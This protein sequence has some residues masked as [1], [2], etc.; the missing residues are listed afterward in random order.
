LH[1]ADIARELGIRTVI[2]PNYPG[3]FCAYGML[4][5]DLKYDVVQ[6]MAMGLEQLDLA[7]ADKQFAVLEDRGRTSL[8]DI[9]VV[10][11]A[12]FVARFADMRYRGQE[13]TLK[14]RLPEKMSFTSQSDMRNAFEAEYT[15]RY[16]HSSKNV[17]I[18]LVNLR[19]V[20]T[21][22]ADKPVMQDLNVQESE[23]APEIRQVNFDGKNFIPCAI[24]QRDKLRVGQ[25]I[26]GP[27]IIEE[28]ASTTLI[29]PNDVATIDRIGNIHVTLGSDQ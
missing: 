13:H 17:P 16:G 27:A 23:P 29:G 8:K 6:T 24:W 21:G 2:V 14:I 25:R 11:A 1:A 18:D 4:Y 3:H 28:S 15:K 9:K 20:V 7:D 12:V 5:A 22:V 26:E 10:P 19:V